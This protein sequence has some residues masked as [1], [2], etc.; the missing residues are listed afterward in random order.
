MTLTFRV[1]HTADIRRWT[2]CRLLKPCWQMQ[3]KQSE[4]KSQ[5]F[6]CMSPAR[7]G[8]QPIH[9]I[10]KRKRADL[11]LKILLQVWDGDWRCFHAT[12]MWSWCAAPLIIRDVRFAKESFPWTGSFER[13]DRLLRACQLPKVWNLIIRIYSYLHVWELLRSYTKQHVL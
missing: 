7:A 10:K 5:I 1:L 11:S 4:R 3:S 2:W 6:F 9:W 13:C 8:C 12:N